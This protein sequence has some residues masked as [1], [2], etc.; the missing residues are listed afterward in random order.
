M[1]RELCI[2]CSCS[3]N[4]AEEFEHLIEKTKLNLPI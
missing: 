2:T 1:A 4:T 3:K